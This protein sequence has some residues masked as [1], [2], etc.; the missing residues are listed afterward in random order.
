MYLVPEVG[1]FR[2]VSP[3]ATRLVYF[4][5]KGKKMNPRLHFVE[6]AEKSVDIL[7]HCRWSACH[8]SIIHQDRDQ[9]RQADASLQFIREP[10][11]TSGFPRGAGATRK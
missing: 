11:V 1:N 2:R 10:D 4:F 7:G 8:Q 6:T 3:A 5:S 9:R